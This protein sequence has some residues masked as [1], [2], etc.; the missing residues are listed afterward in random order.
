[1][2]G[3]STTPAALATV[4]AASVLVSAAAARTS[5]SALCL[6]AAAQAAADTGVP[7]DVLRAIATVESGRKGQPWPWTANFGGDGR[8]Y[9]SAEEAEADVARALSEGAT[10]V[11]LG[12]FQLNYHWHS[13]GFDSLA[14]MLDPSQNATYAAQFLADHFARTGDWA[15]AASAYHSGTPEFAEIYREKFEAVYANLAGAPPPTLDDTSLPVERDNRFPLL[16]AGTTGGR[17]SLVP[18]SSGG[19]RLIGTP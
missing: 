4:L 6:Q 1:M 15:L 14:D 3:K 19:I 16:V 8:W 18:A 2:P 7:Y 12:C 11:D 9:E 17:G 5:P 10:N 13:G